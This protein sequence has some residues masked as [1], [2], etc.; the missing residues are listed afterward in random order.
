[1]ISPKSLRFVFALS[2]SLLMKMNVDLDVPNEYAH[3]C[4]ASADFV[5]PC[6]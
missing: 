5:L 3:V 1:M 2:P 6:S 4:A